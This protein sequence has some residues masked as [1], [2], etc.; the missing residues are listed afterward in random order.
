[1]PKSIFFF[2]FSEENSQF[3]VMKKFEDKSLIG[4]VKV[5]LKLFVQHVYSGFPFTTISV[6]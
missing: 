3:Q 6:V 5:G 1:M 2:Q 4:R